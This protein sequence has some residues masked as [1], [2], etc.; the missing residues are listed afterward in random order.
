[1]NSRTWGSFDPAESLKSVNSARAL[2]AG[3]TSFPEMKM[4]TKPGAPAADDVSFQVLKTLAD[5][6]Q[7]QAQAARKTAAELN[8]YHTMMANYASALRLFDQSFKD[9]RD[10]AEKNH[11]QIPDVQQLNTVLS[12]VRLAYKVYTQTK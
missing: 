4:K 6:V 2:V 11:G 7:T 12:S 8:A 3:G 10:V 9:L 5:R 1:L